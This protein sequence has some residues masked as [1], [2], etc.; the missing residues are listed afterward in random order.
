MSY[1]PCIERRS[2]TVILCSQ[3]TENIHQ[4]NSSIWQIGGIILTCASV[5]NCMWIV[6]CAMH[7]CEFFIVNKAL[8]Y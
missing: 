1:N 4:I 2:G 7:Y 5:Q 6:Q 3:N 8:H